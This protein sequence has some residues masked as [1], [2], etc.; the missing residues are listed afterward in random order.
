[1]PSLSKIELLETNFLY[2]FAIGLQP[3]MFDAEDE[4]DKY[5]YEENSEVSEM[6][7][8]VKGT[9]GIAV[10]AFPLKTTDSFY[11]IAQR[12]RAYQ[13]IADHYV[14]NHR[15]SNFIYIATTNCHGYGIKKKHVHTI[16]AKYQDVNGEIRARV[17]RHYHQHTFK[18]IRDF[19]KAQ[20]TARNS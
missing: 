19:R 9:I 2:D 15:R 18:P 10:N 17:Y 5:I 3:R 6:Y 16:L 7:F 13:L 1:M 20:L 8:F 11:I 12:R 14:V 4:T